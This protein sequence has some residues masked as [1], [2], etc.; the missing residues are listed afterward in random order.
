MHL[1]SQA[2]TRKE[3][4]ADIKRIPCRKEALQG[5]GALMSNP[6]LLLMDEPSLGLSPLMVEEIA[7]I[8]ENV[9]KKGVPVVLVEQNA[10][11]ALGLARYGYVLETGRVT[12]EGKAKDLHENEHVRR[13]YLGT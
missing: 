1:P 12:L 3:P 2:A 4:F 6:K 10:E 13:A 7:K 11:L 8:I 5:L 9:N